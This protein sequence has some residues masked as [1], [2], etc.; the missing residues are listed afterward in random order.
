MNSDQVN[1]KPNL[2]SLSL[3]Q[4]ILFNSKMFNRKTHSRNEID[5]I[6]LMFT[7]F[8]HIFFNRFDF[9]I[10]S[11]S[12]IIIRFAVF[13]VTL[14][15]RKSS[16]SASGCKSNRNFFRAIM[17]L[18]ESNLERDSILDDQQNNRDDFDLKMPITFHSDPK[19]IA[20]H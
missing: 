10:I 16:S 1:A 19:G 17:K 5:E 8:F 4:T 14:A 11:S 20:L 18:F 2:S 7:F 3:Q 13:V 6:N 15:R 9:C 12:L